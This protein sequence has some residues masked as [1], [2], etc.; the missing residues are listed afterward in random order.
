MIHHSSHLRL[1]ASLRASV[2]LVLDDLHS[3]NKPTQLDEVLKRRGGKYHGHLDNQ[4]AV[5]FNIYTNAEFLEITPDRRGLSVGMTIDTP[6]G[7]ARTADAS[8]RVWFWE[9]MS[10]K[11][12]ISGGLVALLWQRGNEIDVHLGTIS[13]SIRDHVA[14]AKQS[15]ERIAIRVSFFDSDVQLRILQEL[16]RPVL[17]REG[18]KLLVEA[19][20]MFA[21]VRPFLEAL[22]VEPTMLPFSRYL[23]L[24]P[25]GSLGEIRIDP[26]VYARGPEFTFQ[27]A[28][29][30]SPESD[31]DDLKLAATDPE[32]IENA[33]LQLRTYS[34]LDPSQADAIVDSL[35]REWGLIQGFV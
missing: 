31:L 8:R 4:D 23:V 5:L 32:S 26:P 14:S 27:L 33:R 9:G 24:Q 30:L 11:R 25:P 21:S 29:L 2:Q 19:T 13:S 22:C 34:T 18:L 20:V 15:S 17:E 12:L 16:R 10:G 7:R 6:P 3:S 35:T 28:S 1:S